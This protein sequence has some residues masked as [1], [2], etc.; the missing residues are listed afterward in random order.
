MGVG[1]TGVGVGG[2]GVVVGGIG[3]AVGRASAVALTL[4]TT[5]ASMSG[6][7]VGMAATVAS[8]PAWTVAAISGVGDRP[9]GR[10]SPLPPQAI[11]PR[12]NRGR[13]PSIHLCIG[14]LY[15]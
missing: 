8:T 14:A 10:D 5:V 2:M 3:V 7:G 12:T 6:V 15:Y 13:M 4:A 11:A 1:G 9:W